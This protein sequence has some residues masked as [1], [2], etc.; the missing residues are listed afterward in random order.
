MF[1]P[2]K[3]LSVVW[4]KGGAFTLILTVLASSMKY[5]KTL[6]YLSGQIFQE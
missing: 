1:N 3:Y 4:Q 2:D 5:G 6:D